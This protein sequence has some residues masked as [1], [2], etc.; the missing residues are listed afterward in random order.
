[1]TGLGPERVLAAAD[2]LLAEQPLPPGATNSNTTPQPTA[3]ISSPPIDVTIAGSAVG[4]A[5]GRDASRAAA[6]A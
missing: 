3:E 5:L 2:E 6:P 1:M 4:S